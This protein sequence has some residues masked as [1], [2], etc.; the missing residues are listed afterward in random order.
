MRL[1]ISAEGC[2]GLLRDGD[3]GARTR[4]RRARMDPNEEDLQEAVHWTPESPLSTV[5]LDDL[6]GGVPGVKK[7]LRL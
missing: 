1:D 4:G 6:V 5:G 7:G 2:G 3:R